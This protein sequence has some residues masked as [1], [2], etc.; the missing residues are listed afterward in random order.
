[1]GAVDELATE[2]GGDAV[3]EQVRGG[4]HPPA[5]AVGGLEDRR[6]QAGLLQLVGTVQPGH[7]AA[8][9][10]DAD[11]A[12]WGGRSRGR[13]VGRRRRALSASGGHH[14]PGRGDHRVA[15][16]PPPRAR[17]LEQL[18]DGRDAGPLARGDGR[19]TQR[20]PQGIEQRAPRHINLRWLQVIS[21]TNQ[22]AL[23]AS[24]RA[25][26]AN[27]ARRRKR[28]AREHVGESEGRSPSG[29]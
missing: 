8:D 10:G 29:E 26:H 6:S 9:N 16:E 15:Q 14:E 13:R 2:L 18:V 1:M 17:D 28:R 24:A 25:S 4:E 5:G 23:R 21:Q 22:P 20:L 7:A 11:A 3:G 19:D 27:G 12:R